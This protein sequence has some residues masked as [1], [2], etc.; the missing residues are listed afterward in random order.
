MK[1]S[2]QMIASGAA[3]LSLIAPVAHAFDYKPIDAEVAARVEACVSEAA[4]G[5]DGT[6]CVGVIFDACEGSAGSTYSMSACFRQETDFWQSMIEQTLPEVLQA[7]D[8]DDRRTMMDAPLSDSL[9]KSQDAWS[10]YVTAQ[11]AFEYDQMGE[12]SMRNITAGACFQ[13]LTAER[14]IFLRGLV[15]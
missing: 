9:K 5:G 7:Y 2:R 12:G 10:A 13:S 15:P 6:A 4:S 8:A 14:A 3:M 1:R 11:C